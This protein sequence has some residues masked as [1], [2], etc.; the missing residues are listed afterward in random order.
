MTNL[1]TLILLALIARSCSAILHLMMLPR[2]F[3]LSTV[4]NPVSKNAQK[5]VP[6][7]TLVAIMYAYTME[8]LQEKARELADMVGNE[9]V[10]GYLPQRTHKRLYRL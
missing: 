1:E 4:C 8:E 9:I 6:P 5:V 3:M 2:L 10:D 7:I